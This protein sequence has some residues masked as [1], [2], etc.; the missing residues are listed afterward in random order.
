VCGFIQDIENVFCSV[1]DFVSS[2]HC[3]A[4]TMAYLKCV[5]AAG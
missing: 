5:H 1:R 3:L 4:G 2:S